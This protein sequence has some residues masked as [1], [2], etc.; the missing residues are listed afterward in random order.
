MK[1]GDAAVVEVEKLGLSN[2]EK[3]TV[4]PIFTATAQRFGLSTL[5]ALDE[6]EISLRR[7][8]AQLPDGA[9]RKAREARALEIRTEIDLALARGQVAV[10]RNR[11]TAAVSGTLAKW[12]YAAAAVGLVIFALAADA[13]SKDRGDQI[14]TAKACAEARKAGATETD[15]HGSGCAVVSPAA[16]ETPAKAS[17]DELRAGLVLRLGRLLTICEQGAVSQPATAEGSTVFG[18]QDCKAIKDAITAVLAA[19]ASR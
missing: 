3:T 14:A 10:V 9:A 1:A 5:S 15:L 6:K 19:S 12:C 18:P 2:A 17:S 7:A 11:A 13:S 16:K 4:D 8:S